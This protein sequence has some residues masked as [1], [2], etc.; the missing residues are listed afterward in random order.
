MGAAFR[1]S[2]SANAGD[3]AAVRDRHSDG[4]LAK[5]SRAVSV[6]L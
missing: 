2:F 3:L 1:G 5:L 4:I 6:S